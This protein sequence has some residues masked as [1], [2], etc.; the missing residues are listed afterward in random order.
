MLT[1]VQV[2]VMIFSLPGYQNRQAGGWSQAALLRL[3]V[4]HWT[5]ILPLPTGRLF[6]PHLNGKPKHSPILKVQLPKDYH[7]PNKQFQ[8]GIHVQRG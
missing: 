6:K 2:S 1:Q 7:A 8:G 3:L 4:T 5:L